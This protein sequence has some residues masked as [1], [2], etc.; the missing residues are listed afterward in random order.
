M[1]AK[2]NVILL[3]AKIRELVLVLVGMAYCGRRSSWSDMNRDPVK[4]KLRLRLKKK[5]SVLNG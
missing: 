5:Y 4:T 2:R 3:S 1:M